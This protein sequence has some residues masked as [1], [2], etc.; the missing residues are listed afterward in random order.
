[1]T[2]LSSP[3]LLTIRQIPSSNA[4]RIRGYLTGHQ[5]DLQKCSQF[6][7]SI[8]HHSQTEW[9]FFQSFFTERE[10]QEKGNLTRLAEK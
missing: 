3:N 8:F 5:A 7:G 6:S 9:Q 4:S 1:M 2:L 10:P